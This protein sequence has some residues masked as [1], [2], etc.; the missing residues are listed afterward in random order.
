MPAKSRGIRNN[1]PGNI[2]RS[3]IEWDGRSAEQNDPTFVTFDE[4]VMGIRALARILCNY[5]RRHGIETVEGAISRW[6][7]ETENATDS[8]V[9]HVADALGVQ[10]DD[11]IDL[12]NEATL[13]RLAKVIIRHENGHNQADTNGEWY[14]DDMI[15]DGVQRALA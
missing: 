12:E 13:C 3:G 6:A 11:P 7:P 9:D 1:N 4:P 5:K 10:P 8:Y 14:S 2:K 15:A